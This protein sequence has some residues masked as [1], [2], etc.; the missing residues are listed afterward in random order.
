MDHASGYIH[1]EL[2]SHLNVPET[3]DAKRFF[4]E[5]C[6]SYGVVPQSYITDEGSSFTSEEY[7]DHLSQ[8]E[9]IALRSAPGG[10][11]SNG[12]AERS[13]G[14]VM[15]I[16]RA[17]LHHSAIHW[18]DVADAEL[19]PLSVL[20]AAYL[21]NRIPKQDTGRSPLEL[22]SRKTWPSCKYQDFHVWGSPV[23]V[24]DASLANG[25]SIPRWQPRS[26]RSM[27]LGNSTNHQHGI[28][29]VLN[30][31]TG[32]ITSQFHVIF[33]D[34]FQTVDSTGSPSVDF[35]SPDWYQTYGLTE[36]Q[37][38]PDDADEPG[39][40]P[41]P[42]SSLEGVDRQERLRAIR[43]EALADTPG[44]LP[45]LR[46]ELDPEPRPLPSSPI[47]APP[48][49]ALRREKAPSAPDKSSMNGSQPDSKAP[50]KPD[51]PFSSVN[52]TTTTSGNTPTPPL[53]RSTRTITKPDIL[54]PSPQPVQPKA[55]E[56]I[57]TP[58]TVASSNI[59]DGNI[60]IDGEPELIC[61]NDSDCYQPQCY[62]ARKPNS[63]P[64][65]L[66][67]D[68]AMA[69]P[70]KED[71][72]EAAQ[73]EIDELAAKGTWYE[74]DK[75]N[76]TTKI[77]P[78]KWVFRR[79]RTSDGTIKKFKA[80]ICLR[81][82][83]QEDNGESNY[84]P[85]SAWPAVRIFLTI[86]VILNWITTSIDFTNAFVQS[87][88]DE[89]VWMHIPRGYKSEKGSN[90]CLRLVKSLYGHK[91][92]PLLW[93]N[94]S[95]EAFKKLGLKQS[96]YEECLWYGKDIMLVQY[97]DDCG[98][99]A[100]TQEHIDRFV[101]GLKDLDLELTQ[102]GSFEEFLGIKFKYSPD[103]TVECTQRGLIQKTLEAA[104][105]VDCNSNSTPTAMNAL[106]SD[107]DG[108]PMK[109]T[110]NYRAICGMLLYL[111]TNTRPDIS[112]A[113]SQ[114]C[115]F[116][117]DPKQSHATAVKM[118]LRYL[119]KTADKGLIINVNTFELELYVDADFC[120]LFGQEDPNDPVSS[121]SRTGYIVRLAGW[122]VIW[123]SKLQDSTTLSTTEAEY[124]ALSD[125][126][127]VFLP[128]KWLVKEMIGETGCP[129]LQDINFTTTV[130]EDNQS[131]F[132]LAT[133][134][135]VTSRT[136]YLLSRY[137][138]FWSHVNK[139]FKLVK[140]PTDEM[141]ADYLTK[142]MP[143]ITFEEN[144]QKVQGW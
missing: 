79:K 136:R 87:R 85:V 57:L 29:L 10:H 11:H 24:L 70:N 114:V 17:M 133:N 86:S 120:G 73:R 90:R 95:S 128:L 139:E 108:L 47:E 99:S 46:R 13:I 28:P 112:F 117:H 92:A 68:E 129:K 140:C 67:W 8:L 31:E 101:Q 64:D 109:E 65:T 55:H 131:A 135:Q 104:G 37:Y 134:Q 41:L 88:L 18:P 137:H 96:E 111:S 77:V 22:F 121:R 26:D 4:E 71:W 61:Y 3:I 83:L 110:W 32:K 30:L 33:D 40:D 35:D 14:S 113:V 69:D 106:G 25:R 58:S 48:R 142:P 78:C 44:S 36:W 42:V 1:I 125:A 122:P 81:G 15:S 62:K 27:Y 100:P 75:S 118:I 144:R 56:A 21:L 82:D 89:P 53:R 20:H 141:L 143:R 45:T 51:R 93:F 115:R 9:Q 43:H 126:L 63:D 80:R 103:G 123:K 130:M 66:T 34:W 7:K 6:F 39:P 119:K 38:I 72:L 50:I 102:E 52:P 127:K 19:W 138:W 98:I 12:I 116:S 76:A 124:V 74:D 23:Y 84:S 132:H 59:L 107:K 97:V 91:R 5:L 60:L 54:D 49:I 2:Q 105:M 94:H 16:S